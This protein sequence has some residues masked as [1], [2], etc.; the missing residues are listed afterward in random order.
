MDQIEIIPKDILSIVPKFDGDG[1]LLNSF[2]R[3]SEYVLRSFT[4]VNQ[5]S[6]DIYNFH[7]ISSR[8]CGKAACL[9]SER[10]DINTWI[11][12]KNLLV[13]HFGDPRSEGCIAIELDSLKIKQ[14]ESYTEFCNRIQSMRSALFS[15]VNLLT[16]EGEKASRMIIYNNT[17]LNTFLYNLPE[18]LLRIVRLKGCTVL[19]TA[20]SIVM[21]EVNFHK[22][23]SAENKNKINTPNNQSPN[24]NFRF[25]QNPQVFMP[26]N[27][28]QNFKFGIP[29]N[30]KMQHSFGAPIPFNTGFKVYNQPNQNYKFGIPQQPFRQMGPQQILRPQSVMP[31]SRP[32]FNQQNQFKFG[33]PNQYLQQKST[34][35]FNR[36]T[37]VSMRTAPPLRQNMLYEP[38]YNEVFYNNE[39]QVH[40]Q[41]PQVVGEENYF[42]NT[43]EETNTLM[44]PTYHETT[45]ENFPLEFTQPEQT[46][47]S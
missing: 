21:E 28:G 37:D 18:D 12:L 16:D 10:D 46:N 5:P 41:N 45:Y 42:Y 4:R 11:D 9:L 6:Q 15:K 44:C 29:P 23:Y 35:V 7:A 24:Q 39:I 27:Y 26:Q 30:N 2:I 19:E 47:F 13:Q 3:K 8:L 34:Q 31:Y 1:S 20:L 17:A 43:N 36:P 38:Q 25:S 33:I 14:G 40:E 22:Q 32:N